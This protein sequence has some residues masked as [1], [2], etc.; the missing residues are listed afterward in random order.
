MGIYQTLETVLILL[1][2]ILLH[3]LVPCGPIW[4]PI[5]FSPKENTFITCVLLKN[6]TFFLKTLDHR[7]QLWKG[8]QD[9]FNDEDKVVL[10][11][12]SVLT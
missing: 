5:I 10:K 6:E 4:A 1:S 12:F 7:W 8:K 3:T 9:N 11:T 2:V